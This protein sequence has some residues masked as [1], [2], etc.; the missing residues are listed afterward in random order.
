MPEI[1]TNTSKSPRINYIQTSQASSL[2]SSQLPTWSPW[3][4]PDALKVHYHIFLPYFTTEFYTATTLEDAIHTTSTTSAEN[5]VVTVSIPVTIAEDHE[6]RINVIPRANCRI[7]VTTE[8]IAVDNPSP[9]HNDVPRTPV[10]TQANSLQPQISR[11]NLS[12][13]PQTPT[14]RNN[15]VVF[16][17]STTMGQSPSARAHNHTTTPTT[18][19]HARSPWV[20]AVDVSSEDEE[21][22]E[23]VPVF[24]PAPGQ[25]EIEHRDQCDGRKYYVLTKGRKI[26]VFYCSWYVIQ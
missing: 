4:A 8:R 10:S 9:S 22:Q 5:I 1:A 12:D 25:R 6:V 21:Y 14:R 13:E 15:T 2:L 16:D 20:D 3:L 23:L 19:T 11:L 18:P 17:T 7:E 24:P 26:G